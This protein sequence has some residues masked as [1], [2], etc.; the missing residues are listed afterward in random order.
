MYLDYADQTRHMQIVSQMFVGH[1]AQDAGV[2]GN[3]VARF[4]KL[5]RPKVTRFG[6]E[7]TT[8]GQ[9][10]ADLGSKPAD[11]AQAWRGFGRC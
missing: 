1:S 7:S 6:R 10:W 5:I 3:K 8:I 9:F 2:R 4:D 11:F